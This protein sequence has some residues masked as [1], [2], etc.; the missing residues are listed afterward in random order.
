MSQPVPHVRGG[1]A[2]HHV[3]HDLAH[4]RRHLR[5]VSAVAHRKPY[6]A[7]L[8]GARQTLYRLHKQCGLWR[9]VGF[10]GYLPLHDAPD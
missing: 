4:V 5:A 3:G 10:I 9:I 8:S 1:I 7:M 2:A 6:A